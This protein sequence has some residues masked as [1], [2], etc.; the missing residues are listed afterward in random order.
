MTPYIR[1]LNFLGVMLIGIAPSAW[2]LILVHYGG[3]D[4]VLQIIAVYGAVISFVSLL[5]WRFQIQP[6][7][8]LLEEL[9]NIYFEYQTLVSTFIITSIL[10][11]PM[12]FN[13]IWYG[14]LAAFLSLVSFSYIGTTFLSKAQRFE[15]TFELARLRNSDSSVSSGASFKQE[16]DEMY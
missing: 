8:K 16:L 11:V 6:V 4:R 1:V 2:S 10:V 14:S 12:A 15:L 5:T 13:I 3:L 9:L 7:F